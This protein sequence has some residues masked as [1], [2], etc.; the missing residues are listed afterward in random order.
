MFLYMMPTLFQRN[1]KEGVVRQ[2]DEALTIFWHNLW[3]FW[4]KIFWT[5]FWRNCS[6]PCSFLYIIIFKQ[7]LKSKHFKTLKNIILK[8]PYQ[9]FRFVIISRKQTEILRVVWCYFSIVSLPSCFVA[10]I[11]LQTPKYSNNHTPNGSN[12][13]SHALLYGNGW[14]YISSVLW[15]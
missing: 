10:M 11:D 2:R 15:H 7:R 8:T 5:C 13:S 9:C 1:C 3:T 14:S 4:S 12:L 6:K